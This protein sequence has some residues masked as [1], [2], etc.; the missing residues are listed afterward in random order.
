M[1]DN[2]SPDSYSNLADGLDFAED[3]DTRAQLLQSYLDLQM[4]PGFRQHSTALKLLVALM[5]LQKDEDR[6]LG[7][8][9]GLIKMLR[10]PGAVAQQ[11]TASDARAAETRNAQDAGGD[12][13]GYAGGWPE[14]RNLSRG[15]RGHR[16]ADFPGRG[17]RGGVPSRSATSSET[18]RSFQPYSRDSS[19]VGK[20]AGKDAGKDLGPYKSKTQEEL[21]KLSPEETAQ[22]KKE[23]A[24]T[25]SYFA[26]ARH[27]RPVR[28][29]HARAHY[30]RRVVPL[31]VRAGSHTLPAHHIHTRACHTRCFVARAAR[32]GSH[33][34]PSPLRRNSIRG[35]PPTE[36]W[37]VN[38]STYTYVV[39]TH[40]P[41][42][43][44]P[45]P[46]FMP[47]ATV[48]AHTHSLTRHPVYPP[49]IFFHAHAHAHAQAMPQVT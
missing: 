24:R 30:A 36:S 41:P 14:N 2:S 19:G 6:D 4:S 11:P 15:G 33:T 43:P 12:A 35:P 40:C 42:P 44:L 28:H 22:L 27:T 29:V 20:D 34:R 45:W 23:Q 10:C 31:A 49:S 21:Y 39:L 47:T 25:R 16:E 3:D 5:K 48:Y 37:E 18:R 46:P 13:G 1:V 38:L 8:N 9:M 26:R 32:V 7:I 17:G